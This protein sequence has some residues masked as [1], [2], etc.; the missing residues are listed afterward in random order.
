L[1]MVGMRALTIPCN[2]PHIVFTK[3]VTT[4]I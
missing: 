2:A 3:T 1:V 4:Q